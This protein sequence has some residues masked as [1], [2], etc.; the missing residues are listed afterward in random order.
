M[1]ALIDDTVQIDVIDS[2]PDNESHYTARFYF[3]PNSVDVGNNGLT[4]F[5]SNDW[6]FCL[7]LWPE[8]VN[9]SMSLC[10]DNDSNN[11]LETER[12]LITDEW[13]SIEVDWKAATAPG[14]DDGY[15][16]LWV[17]EVLATSLENIDND[18]SSID[19]IWLGAL[20]PSS[21][22]NGTVYFDAFDSRQGEHI[23]LDPNGPE[24]Y[25]PLSP[26]D[27]IFAD[28]FES[29]DFSAWS[30][31]VTGGGDLSVSASAAHQGGYGLQAL[32]ND[33]GNL[34]VVDES[35]VSEDHYRARFYFHPNSIAMSSGSSHSI[36]DGVNTYYN[37]VIF[38]TELFYENGSYKLQPCDEGRLGL[39]QRR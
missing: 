18:A 16:R 37:M 14:A 26:P 10:G 5:A 8:G 17:G 13:Q 28:D 30:K 25:S 24:V 3:D 33:T 36:F 22:T 19:T 34:R 39:H 2:S 31:T 29:G 27:L 23:G 9:Y 7:Y 15:I 11:W 32:I 1:Q 20:S 12:V 38:R 4:L 6:H 21:G 35:P